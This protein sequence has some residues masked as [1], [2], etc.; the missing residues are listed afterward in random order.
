MARLVVAGMSYG[1]Y[2]AATPPAASLPDLDT[3]SSNMNIM[4]VYGMLQACHVFAVFQF[5]QLHNSGQHPPN[6]VHCCTTVQR[7]AIITAIVSIHEL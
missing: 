1:Y 6:A 5:E 2:P 4:N 3:L 7:C